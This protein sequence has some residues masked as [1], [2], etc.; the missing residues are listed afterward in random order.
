MFTPS[1][2]ITFAFELNL[3]LRSE[4]N[5]LFGLLIMCIVF[6]GIAKTNFLF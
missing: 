5:A 4:N 6:A 2:I 1:F 3:I